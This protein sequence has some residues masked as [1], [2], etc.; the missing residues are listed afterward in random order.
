[1]NQ[2]LMAIQ[3][4]TDD[5]CEKTGTGIFPTR[6]VAFKNSLMPDGGMP[7]VKLQCQDEMMRSLRAI[8]PNDSPTARCETSGSDSCNKNETLTSKLVMDDNVRSTNKGGLTIFLSSCVGLFNRRNCAVTLDG[9]SLF[10]CLNHTSMV[11]TQQ[12]SVLARHTKFS[13]VSKVLNC[14]FTLT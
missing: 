7:F 2:C 3:S 9:V 11:A 13:F 1:M 12:L 8:H 6:A 5:T 14:A 10:Q 4:M